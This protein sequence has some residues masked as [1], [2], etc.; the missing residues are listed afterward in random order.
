MNE[1]KIEMEET[2]GGVRIFRLTGPLILNTVFEFQDL[3]RAHG[4]SGIL[5][6][7]SGVPYMD[8]AGLGAVLG[9]MAS[10]QRKGHGFGITGMT[11]RVTMLL[12]VSRVDGLIPTFQSVESAAC[13]LSRAAS[14]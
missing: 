14:A 2:A 7:L 4:D 11:D 5:L 12:K 3:A 10:C 1:L 13:G 9:I 6:E 8:S